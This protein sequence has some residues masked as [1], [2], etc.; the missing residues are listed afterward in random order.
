MGAENSSL[1]HAIRI[2]RVPYYLAKLIGLLPFREDRHIHIPSRAIP[3][4]PAAVIWFL[5][6][7][8]DNN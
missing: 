8:N 6:E 3:L 5:K 1:G 2:V 7:K 4:R